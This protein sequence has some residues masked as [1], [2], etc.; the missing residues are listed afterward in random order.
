MNVDVGVLNRF[1]PAFA[2]H[3]RDILS[4]S[5]SIEE[6]SNIMAKGRYCLAGGAIRSYYDDTKLNDL[7]IYVLDDNTWDEMSSLAQAYS[8]EE[9]VKKLRASQ[10]GMY[11]FGARFGTYKYPYKHIDHISFDGLKP[12]VEFLRIRYVPDYKNRFNNRDLPKVADLTEAEFITATSTSEILEGF[13]FICCTAAVEFEVSSETNDLFSSLRKTQQ[14]ITATKKLRQLG[15]K[16][17]NYKQHPLFLTCIIKKD[18]R[19]TPS[20]NMQKCGIAYKR[21]YKYFS[22]GYRI[23]RDYDFKQLEMQ[24]A[25]AILSGL[26]ITIAQYDV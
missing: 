21:L 4:N 10:P 23:L 19:L 24:R 12:R 22:Y 3:L 1:D 13:D 14:A 25:E 5:L 20:K 17:T 15:I 7:D 26:D 18:L 8:A 2:S 6:V 16:L 11:S 9:D